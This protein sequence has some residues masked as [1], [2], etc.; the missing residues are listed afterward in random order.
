MKKEIADTL[1]K[2]LEQFEFDMDES[3]MMKATEEMSYPGLEVAIAHKL[4][5]LDMRLSIQ[6]ARDERDLFLKY[7]KYSE[8]YVFRYR[9]LD[10]S[11]TIKTDDDKI[12]A[13]L[14]PF[15]DDHQKNQIMAMTLG[16][17]SSE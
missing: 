9:Y 12:A 17:K 10:L 15:F 2:K 5:P 7:T 13:K 1:I 16:S 8:K 3:D 14:Y 11:F 4:A 6:P